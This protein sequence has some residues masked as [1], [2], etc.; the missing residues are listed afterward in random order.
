MTDTRGTDAPDRIAPG[1]D[2]IAPGSDGAGLARRLYRR[3]PVRWL[4]TTVIAH[5]GIRAD[6]VFVAS[7]PRSGS[8]WLRFLIME[9]TVGGAS[10]KDLPRTLPELGRQRRG[11]AVLPGGGRVIKTHEPYSARYRRAVHLVRDPRDVAISYFRFM[12]RL[13]KIVVRPTDDLAASFDHFIDALIA[14]RIDA[15]GTWQTH[16]LSWVRAADEQRS[17]ILRLRYEDLAAEPVAGVGRIGRWLGL[18]L[19]PEHAAR[20]VE[21]CSLDRMRRSEAERDQDRV[22]RG[23]RISPAPQFALVNSGRVDAWRAELTDQQVARLG[24]FAEGLE[25]MGYPPR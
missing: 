25:L 6:D 19:S 15:H 7:Y 9:M 14:G 21:A 1:S 17:D 10:F 13:G 20:V 24:A 11:P 12:Q 5:H 16:L 4:R 2:R 8:V 23:I 3:S 22:A 18:D